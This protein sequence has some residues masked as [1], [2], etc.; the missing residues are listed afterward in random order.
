MKR[1]IT[2]AAEARRI[3]DE[4]AVLVKEGRKVADDPRLSPTAAFIKANV[5]AEFKT[6]VKASRDPR[7][8][9]KALMRAAK[10]DETGQAVLGLKASVYDH[11]I[12]TAI[13]GEGLLGTKMRDALFDKRFLAAIRE[14][15]TPVEFRQLG[16]NIKAL[17]NIEAR[18]G[19]LPDV[20]G[21]LNEPTNTAIEM[22]GRVLSA[23][24]GTRI[25]KATGGGSVQVPGMFA[26]QAKRFLKFL[27][28][29]KGR[30]ILREAMQPTPEGR[31]LFRALLLPLDTPARI[32]RV[33]RVLGPFLGGA[34]SAAVI[35]GQ[36][37]ETSGG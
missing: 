23:G 7:A 25:A 24:Q 37:D 10:K 3:S 28:N 2:E 33:G 15:L 21:V 29:D 11:L 9:A 16:K 31:E 14:I 6:L 34:G 26:T 13:K 36:R 22:I 12:D 19:K 17:K 27:T 5:G 32:E 1:Q 8:A 18:A 30:E 20:G 35:E 4:L